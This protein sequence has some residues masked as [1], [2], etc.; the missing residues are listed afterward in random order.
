MGLMAPWECWKKDLIPGLA[1]WV[2]D[3]ALL[4][5]WLRLQLQLGSDSW[6]RNSICHGVVKKIKKI[7][8][9]TNKDLLYSTEN[10]TQYF[11]VTYKGKES[12]KK[13]FMHV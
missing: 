9:I 4:Q 3:M 8:Y 12:E 13:S 10:Y 1:Q 2:K 6:P 7:K 11:V 5:L